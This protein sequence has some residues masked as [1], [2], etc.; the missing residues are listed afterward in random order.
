MNGVISDRSS[1]ASYFQEKAKALV[2]QVDEGYGEVLLEQMIRRL[3]MTVREF[4][5]EIDQLIERLRKNAVEYEE[6]MGRIRQKDEAAGLA[7]L[8]PQRESTDE[9]PEWEKRLTE[10]EGPPK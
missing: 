10:L 3:E 9:V 4:E 5:A 2:E 8:T 1:K 6:L 7:G